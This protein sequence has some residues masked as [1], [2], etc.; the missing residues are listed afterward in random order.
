MMKVIF[1]LQALIL[2]KVLADIRCQVQ[3]GKYTC[4]EYD[5]QILDRS[6]SADSIFLKETKKD[7]ADADTDWGD[8]NDGVDAGVG[9][10][11]DTVGAIKDPTLGNVGSA[12]ASAG[13]LVAF[14]PP[15]A[16]PLIGGAMA[17]IGGVMGLFD[18]TPSPEEIMME[19]QQ[20]IMEN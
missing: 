6:P 1:V 17:V 9:A 16:G 2:V 20:K 15:P 12:I 18:D 14:A 5:R 13:A 4:M 19:N 7:D 10:L 3:Y 8:F 11:T